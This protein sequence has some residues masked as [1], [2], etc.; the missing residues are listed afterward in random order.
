MNR[1]IQFKLIPT[2]TKVLLEQFQNNASLDKIN[3]DK[4][5]NF[6]NYLNKDKIS[7]NPEQFPSISD[8]RYIVKHVEKIIQKNPITLSYYEKRILAEFALSLELWDI[9]PNREEITN[10]YSIHNFLIEY[11]KEY[12]D[13]DDED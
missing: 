6:T 13:S 11:E 8:L 1:D 3:L 4:I 10:N 9:E 7:F 12:F 2:H 5:T